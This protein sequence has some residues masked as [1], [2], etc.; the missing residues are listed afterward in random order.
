GEMQALLTGMPALAVDEQRFIH[1]GLRQSS[2]AAA[3]GIL[4]L[5]FIV[6]RSM[7]Q[8]VG[9][10]LP[11][12][13]GTLL[14][15]GVVRLLFGELNLVTSSFVSVLMGLGIDFSVHIV[16][17]FNEARRAGDAPLAAMQI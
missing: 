15:L 16:A 9:A 5:F 12:G 7:R 3:F 1:T 13:I 8:T 11:L 2:V 10:L 6:F 4:A 14:T 17:R